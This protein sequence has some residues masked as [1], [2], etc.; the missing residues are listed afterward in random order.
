MSASIEGLRYSFFVLWL[1]LFLPLWAQVD[2]SRSNY[3]LPAE[4]F[5]ISLPV[6]LALLLI[7]SSLPKN[8][9]SRPRLLLGLWLALFL[10]AAFGALFR[11]DYP[12]AAWPWIGY[13]VY[14]LI[15]GVPLVVVVFKRFADL[16][17]LR[18]TVFAGFLVILAYYLLDLLYGLNWFSLYVRLDV[19]MFGSSGG[20]DWVE[21]V[22]AWLGKEKWVSYRLIT[23]VCLGYLIAKHKGLI[24][25]IAI[26]MVIALADSA[27][28]W[29]VF[30]PNDGEFEAPPMRFVAEYYWPELLRALLI[31][32]SILTFF[33]LGGALITRFHWRRS[34]RPRFVPSLKGKYRP[35]RRIT[36]HGRPESIGSVR[37]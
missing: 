12:I 31:Q 8:I 10:R 26:S 1:V 15:I 17:M 25:S 14:G 9:G 24:W 30:L 18:L 19:G 11:Y 2:S 32:V 4:C 7:S 6:A 33:A 36:P 5:F 28:G 13:F 37:S 22:T 29:L 21:G 35:A 27:L 20:F 23:Y 3:I 16:G 34:Y